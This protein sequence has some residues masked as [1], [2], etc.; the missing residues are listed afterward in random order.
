MRKWAWALMVVA[1]ATGGTAMA[2]VYEGRSYR[3]W[4]SEKLAE[5][6]DHVK[7]IMQ[8]YSPGTRAEA[9]HP[10]DVIEIE[11]ELKAM[12]GDIRDVHEGNRYLTLAAAAGAIAVISAVA[13]AALLRKVRRM[14]V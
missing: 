5:R 10:E 4:G 3:R 1:I 14:R 9:M 7:A 12:D 8:K 13:S 2:F 6:Q 11:Y